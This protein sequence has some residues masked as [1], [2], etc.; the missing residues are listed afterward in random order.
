MGLTGGGG[1]GALVVVVI[2]VASL[3]LQLTA[4]GLAL[5]LIWVTGRRTAWILISA[6]IVLMSV[7]RAI[8]LF[9]LVAGGPP[10]KHDLPAEVV[11]LAISILMVAGLLGIGRLFSALRDSESVLKQS[12]QQ[13]RTLADSTYDWESWLDNDGNYIYVSPSCTRITGYTPEEFL[14]DPDLILSMVHRDDRLRVVRHIEQQHAEGSKG[15]LEFRL[16]HKDGRQVWI[17]HHCQGVFDDQGRRDGQ[18]C[19]NHDITDRKRVQA[20]MARCYAMVGVL[21]HTSLRFLQETGVAADLDYF[22]KRLGAAAEVEHLVVY[23]KAG[24]GESKG[25][26]LVHRW[27]AAGDEQASRS[28]PFM[29]VLDIYQPGMEPWAQT[30]ESGGNVVSGGQSFPP[31][32]QEARERW[33]V[34]SLALVPVMSGSSLWGF[35]AAADTDA[36]RSWPPSELGILTTAGTLIAALLQPASPE[37]VPEA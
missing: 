11:A 3:A 7:R 30:L 2:L 37:P 13:F 6:A 21:C 9:S 10:A 19:S 1:G 5:R 24:A 15:H 36:A 35:L 25:S 14:A 31:A 23:Q 12:R 27:T 33:G 29:A 4:M 8:T 17:S 26:R 20:E 28:A 16:M 18:R 32:L 22:I 34:E